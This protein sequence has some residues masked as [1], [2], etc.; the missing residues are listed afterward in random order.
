MSHH[1]LA[2]LL[3]CHNEERT[4]YDV[5]GAFRAALPQATIYVY[6]NNSTDRTAMMAENAGAVVRTERRQGKGNVI[7]RMFADIDADI[8]VMADG[9]ATYDAA[10]APLLIDRLVSD[11]LD[12][13]VGT[14]A[15]AT[16]RA[17]RPG[18]AF[19]NRLLTGSVMAIFGHGQTDI[20]SGYRAFSRRFVKSFPATSRGFETEAEISVHALS[21]SIP[22]GEIETR[23]FARPAGSASKLNT[24]RDGIRIL[25][26]IAMLFKDN[27]PFWFFS[28]VALALATLSVGLSLPVILEFFATGL[29]PRLPTAVLSASIMLAALVAFAAGIILDSV[30][31][32]RLEQKRLAY[33]ALP[34]LQE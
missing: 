24:Y 29:V 5:V 3:P 28:L 25:T 1:R 14:R 32:G 27:K 10:M 16:G 8:F 20:L 9:D 6:D 18:H 11:R 13:V 26:F 22:F 15:A 7:R 31:R 30:S 4:I 17:Y 34:P 12:M 2:V 21:L 19:G 33:L 23:Y